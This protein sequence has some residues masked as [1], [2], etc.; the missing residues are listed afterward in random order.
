MNPILLR[1]MGFLLVAVIAGAGGG[2]LAV[3][4]KIVSPP[5]VT[6]SGTTPAVPAQPF[7]GLGIRAIPAKPATPAILR[8]SSNVCPKIPELT[9]LSSLD[10]GWNTDKPA[11]NYWITAMLKSKNGTIFTAGF[12]PGLVDYYENGSLGDGYVPFMYKSTDN[13]AHWTSI[14]LPPATRLWTMIYAMAE[15]DNGTLYAAGTKVWKSTDGG[16]TW[17]VLPMP[18]PGFITGGPVPETYTISAKNN[19]IIVAFGDN[20]FANLYPYRYFEPTVFQSIDGGKTWTK[21]FSHPAPITSVLE[22]NDGSILFREYTSGGDVYRYADGVIAKTFSGSPVS[23]EYDAGLLKAND[24]FIYFI[25]PDISIDINTVYGA[26][27]DQ[28]GG[29]YLTAYKSGDNGETW[30]KLGSLPNSWT[31]QGSIIEA[32][33]GTMFVHSYSICYESNSVI[34]KST[35]RGVS[36]KEAGYAQKFWKK[37]AD[38]YFPGYYANAIV[39]TAGKVLSGGNTPLIFTTK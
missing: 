23:I 11:Q 30:T 34:Y 3:N 35:D 14:T 10:P 1:Y 6:R 12:K 27:Y 22:A 24:G 4:N 38:L 7:P 5:S 15:D 21:L 8:A 13:G 26:G 32:P 39:E 2:Y 9:Q 17:V 29:A 16:N 31:I 18:Y 20:A 36:W 25:G 33:N 28:P 19:S 37:T